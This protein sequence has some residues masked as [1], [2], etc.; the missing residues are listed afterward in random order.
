ML[1]LI[2]NELSFIANYK[3]L[4]QINSNRKVTDRRSYHTMQCICRYHLLAVI[5]RN[6]NKWWYSPKFNYLFVISYLLWFMTYLLQLICMT[7]LLFLTDYFAITYLLFLICPDL[8]VIPY[9][10]HQLCVQAWSQKVF[11]WTCKYDTEQIMAF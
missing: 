9:L 6:T 2:C 11:F 10:L 4:L 8:I 1:L 3:T 7:Y 5:P